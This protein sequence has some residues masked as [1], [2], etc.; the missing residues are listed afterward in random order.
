MSLVLNGTSGV[1]FPNNTIQASA[2]LVLQVVNFQTYTT[3][4]TTSNAF[5]ATA[6]TASITPKF[7]TS[8]IL[9]IGQVFV[10]ASGNTVQPNITLYRDSSNLFGGYGI[11]DL[12][13]ASAGLM[14]AILPFSYLDSPTTTSSVAY[15]I[16]GRTGTSGTATFVDALRP[17]IITLLEIAG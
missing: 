14:E 9:I 7:S 16:Y 3:T 15:T 12:Y 5:I 6:V 17:G 4:V 10:T 11:G 8:K 13:G 1:T 2:G